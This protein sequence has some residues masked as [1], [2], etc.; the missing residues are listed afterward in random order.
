[1]KSIQRPF[2]FLL[3][4]LIVFLTSCSGSDDTPNIAAIG[5]LVANV[6]GS[7]FKASSKNI[8]AQLFQY[9]LEIHALDNVGTSGI[10]LSIDDPAVGSFSIHNFFEGGAFFE[11]FG[12]GPY[13]T[14]EGFTG[15]GILE[16]TK[17]NFGTLLV[18]GIFR[19]EAIN[20]KGEI[21]EVKE[22]SFTDI[23]MIESSG[24]TLG[25]S[26]SATI[27]GESYQADIVSCFIS[28]NTIIIN[29]T[30][31][32]TDER[33]QFTIRTTVG[34]Q[35]YPFDT[36]VTPNYDV[37]I[38]GTYRQGLTASNIYTSLTGTIEIVEYKLVESVLTGTFQFS[39]GDIY[40][41]DPT[42]VELTQ[43]SFSVNIE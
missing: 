30:N 26:L 8:T 37:V 24:S 25:N 14:T 34:E 21:I 19:F 12:E 18:S 29:S 32:S 27:D 17:I 10:L 22:G 2:L 31:T 9:K 36:A 43:G 38:R 41:N 15:T 4:P 20:I 35:I 3:I 6:D 1:M 39:A 13:S 23:S 33:I 40:G 42:V 11:F 7:L 28:R 5:E 16:I